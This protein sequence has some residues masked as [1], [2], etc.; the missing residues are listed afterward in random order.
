M[1]PCNPH[2]PRLHRRTPRGSRQRRAAGRQ[3]RG[4]ASSRGQTV[5]PCPSRSTG[6]RPTSSPPPSAAQPASSS[7]SVTPTPS[8]SGACAWRPP[9][10]AKATRPA[11][12]LRRVGGGRRLPRPRGRR[13]TLA[14]SGP[15]WRRR[16]SCSPRPFSA[17]SRSRRLPAA[18][19]PAEEGAGAEEPSRL[20]PARGRHERR[21]VRRLRPIGRDT[22]ECFFR[23]CT[24]VVPAERY[25]CD[26]HEEIIQRQRAI[27]ARR[28]SERAKTRVRVDRRDLRELESDRRLF[29]VD[30]YGV[31][32]RNG[33]RGRVM[34]AVYCG[35]TYGTLDRSEFDR[36][37]SRRTSR[38]G[39]RLTPIGLCI[40]TS[41][42]PAVTALSSWP[43]RGR[44][45]ATASS[46]ARRPRSSSTG[47]PAVSVPSASRKRRHSTGSTFASGASRRW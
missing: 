6:R 12:E 14:A 15:S 43:E 3:I 42:A 5:I 29:V 23:R 27:V 25:H 40:R 18:A 31:V 39:R 33:R 24:T 41:A 19:A 17:S 34:E 47:T 46:P 20:Q 7:Q 21:R 11:P 13:A 35:V 30:R 44:G 9:R 32:D 10:S 8:R 2:L 22:H 38:C 37:C 28:N 26:R 45:A 4:G 16:R 1:Q 36:A